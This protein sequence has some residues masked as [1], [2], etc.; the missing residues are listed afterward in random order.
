MGRGERPGAVV[1]Q[2]ELA[3]FGGHLI[4]GAVVRGAKGDTA[5]DHR[6]QRLGAKGKAVGADFDI[7][8]AGVPEA[9]V[10]S[11]EGVV[12][13]VDEHFD[14][15]AFAVFIQAVGDHLAHRDLAVVH[16]RTDPQRT[17]IAGVQEKALARFAIG[18][19]RWRFE[20]DEGL[21]AGVRFAGV[22]ADEI[23]GQQGIDTRHA[24]GADACPH[25]PELGIHPGEIVGLLDQ[26]D[27]GGDAL[28]VLAQLH[29]GDLADHHI[30][31]LDR[32]LVGFQ[33]LTGLEGDLDGRAL[34]HDVVHHQRQ[35]HQHR[36]QRHDPHQRD[37]ETAGLDPGLAGLWAVLAGISHRPAP[38]RA[39]RSV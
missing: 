6:R 28:L 12:G 29:G 30:A 23:T 37:A 26:L 25:H 35:A 8:T 24:A 2:L 7:D 5:N 1:E 10:V 22:G 20:A 3:V 18:D 13:R 27:R 38:C 39:A 15:D 34:L 33:A 36:H 17:E 32:G 9:G 19:R 4:V 11:D 21:G 31:V 14:T 16:R